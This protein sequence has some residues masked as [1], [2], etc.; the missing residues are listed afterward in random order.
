MNLS[1]LERAGSGR[2][3]QQHQTMK[4]V[5]S[6][7]DRALSAIESG[8]PAFGTKLKVRRMKSLLCNLSDQQLAVIGV[9][10]S[11]IKQHA[12]YLVGYEYDG[13]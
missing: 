5:I 7:M 8:M 11:K 4:G 6:V 1:N 2:L 10:R 3:P 12:E 9:K 13:L